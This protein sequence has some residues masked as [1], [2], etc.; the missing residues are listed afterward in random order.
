LSAA[1]ALVDLDGF[2]AETIVRKAMKI[3]GDICIYTNHNITIE[4][5]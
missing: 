4:K 3:A 2:D 1:R 5:L